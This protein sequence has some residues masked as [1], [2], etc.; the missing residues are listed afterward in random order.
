MSY[1]IKFYNEDGYNI[2][3]WD[4]INMRNEQNIIKFECE[5]W[6]SSKSNEC[7]EGVK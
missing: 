5:G 4:A 1:T 6:S 7:S 3:I 2:S